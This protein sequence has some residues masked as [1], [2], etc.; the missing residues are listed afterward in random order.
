MT[1][2]TENK[3]YLKGTKIRKYKLVNSGRWTSYQEAL[4]PEELALLNY[5][6]QTGNVGRANDAPRGGKAGEHYLILKYFTT[7]SLAKKAEAEKKVLKEKLDKVLKSERKE[8]FFTNSDAGAINIDGISYSNF[9]G[10]G[11]NV[12]EVC[13]TNAKD[14]KKAELLSC[15]QVYNAGEPI[16]IVKL[17]KVKT[18]EIAEDD[19]EPNGAKIK[20]DN[21]LGF[22]IWSRKVKVFVKD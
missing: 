20:I 18:I 2:K 13:T 14:F 16:T 9:Y 10:D 8:E 11:R 1:T 22:C 12:I 17:P 4:D 3:K 21:V 15:R 19:C 5:G 6:C 7:N